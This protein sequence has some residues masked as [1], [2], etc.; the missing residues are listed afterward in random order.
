MSERF[1][2]AYIAR[3]GAGTAQFGVYAEEA[4]RLLVQYEGSWDGTYLSS[5]DPNEQF[6]IDKEQATNWHTWELEG[7]E[8]S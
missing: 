6:W 7:V 2:Y 5:L 3:Y 4:T 1:G 8:R